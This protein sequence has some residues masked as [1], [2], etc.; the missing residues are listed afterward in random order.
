MNPAVTL[1]DVV[2][3]FDA[4]NLSVLPAGWAEAGTYEL[5]TSPRLEAILTEA[6]SPVRLRARRYAAARAG[7]GLAG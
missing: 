2:Q 7:A 5:L 3:R 4:L 6:R 1:P